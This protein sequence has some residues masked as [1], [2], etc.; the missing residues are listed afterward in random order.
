MIHIADS[1]TLEWE[2]RREGCPSNGEN[3]GVICDGTKT[4]TYDEEERRVRELERAHHPA[5]FALRQPEMV[6]Q[7]GQGGEE[8]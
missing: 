6:L 8:R 5:R 1:P 7:H 3:D 2:K 4:V